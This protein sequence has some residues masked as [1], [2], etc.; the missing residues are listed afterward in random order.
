M[1]RRWAGSELPIA[2]RRERKE[3]VEEDGQKRIYDYPVVLS[4][5]APRALG[6]QF[7][8]RRTPIVAP[9]ARYSRNCQ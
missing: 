2:P 9:F 7:T 1:R 8:D 4:A 6:S 5:R 3:S